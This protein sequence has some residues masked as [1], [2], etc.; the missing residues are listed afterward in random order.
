[1]LGEEIRVRMLAKLG[2]DW[3]R[4]SASVLTD[5]GIGIIGIGALGFVA[6]L[7]LLSVDVARQREPAL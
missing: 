7:I 1:M 2:V 4:G 6:F 3:R 5:R